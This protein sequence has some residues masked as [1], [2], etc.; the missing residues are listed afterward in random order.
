M[1]VT[2]VTSVLDRAQDVLGDQKVSVDDFIEGLGHASFSPLLLLPALAVVTPL[3]GI[4]LFSS[5]CGVLIF[6]I[7]AQMLM[8]RNHLWLPAWVR[9]QRIESARLRTG[10]GK[11]KGVARWFDRHRSGRL[12]FLFHRPFISILRG[13]CAICGV[14]MPFLEIVPF[15]SSLLGAV[16]SVLAIAMLI[17]DGRLALIALLG[18]C[19][20]V[21]GIVYLIP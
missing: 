10:L 17:R 21:I 19:G 4:P 8:G 15:S 11:V 6:L 1:T 16:V 12:Q 13:I 14:L 20:A 2:S 7:S 9:R 3:S 5:F 18:L